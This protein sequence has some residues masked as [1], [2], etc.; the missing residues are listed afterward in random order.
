MRLP[1][2]VNISSRSLQDI[3]F[4][5][6]VERLLQ[7]ATVPAELLCLEITESSIMVDPERSLAVLERLRTLGVRLSIDDFGTGYSSM[8]YLKLLPVQELKI[9][10]SF[11]RD[12]IADAG[13]QVIVR[14]A[15][16]LGHEFGLT[17]IAEGVEDAVTV[18]ALRLLGADG[19]Q[20]YHLGRP[21]P[22]GRLAEWIRMHHR[23]D[24]EARAVP[25]PGEG[26]VARWE[27]ETAS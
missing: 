10:S 13:S 20:G 22:A 14:S 6:T 16:D 15:V 23:P 12:M 26:V 24:G 2:A 18:Q 3:D 27:P 1:V 17:V 11:V 25:A 21:M 7:V 5:T 4:P 19:M 8:A 9:D